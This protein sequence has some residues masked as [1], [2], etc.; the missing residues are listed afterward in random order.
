MRATLVSGAEIGSGS[1]VGAQSLVNKKFPNNSLIA[2]NP[3]RIIRDKIA[4]RR[5]CMPL[6]DTYEDFKEF[7]YTAFGSRRD[8]R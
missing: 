2:G 8:L 3:A 4:W 1:M 7:D 5:E 6:Y